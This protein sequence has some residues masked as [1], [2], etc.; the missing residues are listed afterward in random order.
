MNIKTHIPFLDDFLRVLPT[1]KII[2]C[3]YTIAI[4]C[5]MILPMGVN[6]DE[7][8][9][10]PVETTQPKQEAI[11]VTLQVTGV[12]LAQQSIAITSETAGRIQAIH[13]EDGQPVEKGSLIVN[14]EDN[15]LMAE[16]KQA[17]AKVDHAQ[18]H[19]QRLERLV[20]SG[21]AKSSELD[22]AI[23]QHKIVDAQLGYIEAKINQTRLYA[24]F[25]G[26][27]G[28][29]SVEPGDYVTPG[30]SLVTLESIETLRVDF[31]VPEIYLAQLNH[32]KTF[33][34]TFDG[35]PNEQFEGQIIAIQPHANDHHS[36]RVRGILNNAGLTLRPGLFVRIKLVLA[37]HANALLVPEHAVSLSP[38]G[39]YVYRV[40]EQKAEKVMVKT[41]LRKPGWVEIKEGISL[42]DTIIISG[43]NRLYDGAVTYPAPQ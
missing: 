10:V 37:H 24:P 27:I 41:G 15:L 43:Q 12:L 3:R 4:I 7:P 14:L 25:S 32:A 5:L 40:F 19:H 1:R 39:P 35:L 18:A 2:C 29:F 21:S 17:K 38:Q 23:K 36:F 9:P 6:A 34:L 20:A 22:D 33:S 31:K 28:L 30:Q 16:Y 42:E 8:P 13:V 11:D 26:L